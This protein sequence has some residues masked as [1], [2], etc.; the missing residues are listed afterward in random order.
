MLLNLLANEESFIGD[1]AS[2]LL[3]SSFCSR[4]KRDRRS[5]QRSFKLDRRG[6]RGVRTGEQQFDD[7]ELPVAL[8]GATGLAVVKWSLTTSEYVARRLSEST[9]SSFP[10]DSRV[11]DSSSIHS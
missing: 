4:E 1:P 9:L 8:E 11:L 2:Q 3:S 5:V 10:E 6:Q 7:G